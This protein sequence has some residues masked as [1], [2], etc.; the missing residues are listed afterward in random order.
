MTKPD[1]AMTFAYRPYPWALRELN[2][3]PVS[4]KAVAETLWNLRKNTRNAPQRYPARPFYAPRG[5]YAILLNDG[6]KDLYFHKAT[7]RPASFA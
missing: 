7:V 1:F 3:Y 2:T 5:V 6:G 4:R